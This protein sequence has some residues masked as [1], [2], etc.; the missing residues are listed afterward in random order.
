MTYLGEG[1]DLSA[2]A[3]STLAGQETKGA[4]TGGFVLNPQK[5]TGWKAYIC[6]PINTPYGDCN[7][8]VSHDDV[9]VAKASLTSF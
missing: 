8:Q 5:S 1:L 3:R 4:V 9:G 7:D 6:L 2:V